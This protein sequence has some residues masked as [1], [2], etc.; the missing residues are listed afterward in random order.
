MT[1]LKLEGVKI[2]KRNLE[3]PFVF[4]IFAALF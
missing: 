4:L 3:M 1:S 2:L